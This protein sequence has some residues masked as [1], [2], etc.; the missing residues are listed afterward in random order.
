MILV[1]MLAI[2]IAGGLIVWPLARLHPLLSRLIALSAVTFDLALAL[3]LAVRDFGPGTTAGGGWREELDWSWI[4]QFGIH[5]H[6]GMDGLS[7]LLVLLTLFLGLV[8]VVVSWREIS[9][10]VG[11]YHF[12]LL[13][14]LVGILGVLLSLDLFLFYFSWE[15][16]LVPMYFLISVWGRER[17]IRAAVK[18]FLFTQLS[19]LL[20]LIALLALYFAHHQAT[21]VYT[22]EYQ[23]L[24][25]TPLGPRAAM[26]MM[27]G[28]LAAFAVKLPIFP[29]HT[30]LPDVCAEASAATNL[31]L[32]SLMAA[33]AAY[34]MIRFLLPLFPDAVH[35]ISPIMIVL[36]VI[37]ILYSAILAFSQTNLMR[38]VAYASI[39]HLGFVL[40]GIFAGNSL[41]LRGA[42]MT[43][44]AHAISIGAL[45]LVAG[46]I[47]KRVQS[48]EIESMGG[49]WETIPR[50]S[51][52]GLFFALAALGLPGLGDFIGEFL[53]LIGTYQG[54]IA[55]A[56]VAACG[57][58]AATFY[59]L[60]FVQCTFQGPN[61]HSWQLP[62]LAP[63]EALILGVLMVLLLWLGLY[64]QPVFETLGHATNHAPAQWR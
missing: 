19:G 49:L 32:A 56:A 15:L 57:V 44:I 13:L 61:H 40:L 64:P 36:A 54:H 10:A 24:L 11:F 3:F 52:V 62:D 6:L 39:G 33:S 50:L 25:G 23:D 16:M 63:R 21:G 18:F 41:A 45:F 26:W 9:T 28:F 27:L 20:M 34:A 5:F 42:V 48:R 2:L 60:R 35:A 17:R 55:V 47:E 1:W 53:I 12:N 59:A 29:F 7:F 58:F 51:G 4:P 46:S 38:L 43:I 22:F 30:W 37:G 8:A 14:I 31:V